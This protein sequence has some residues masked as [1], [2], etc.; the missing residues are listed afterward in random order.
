M[1]E[2]RFFVSSKLDTRHIVPK[3]TKIFFGGI[4][5]YSDHKGTCM[6]LKPSFIDRTG[7]R[8]GVVTVIGLATTKPTQATTI[9]QEVVHKPSWRLKCDCQYEWDVPIARVSYTAPQSCRNCQPKRKVYT[10]T[11]V[12]NG[13]A[14]LLYRSTHPNY[15]SWHAMILRCNDPKHIA[16]QRYGGRGIKVCTRWLN[17]DLFT[18]DMGTKPS[19]L[20][21]IDRIDNDLGYEPSNCR[22]ATSKEQKANQRPR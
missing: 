17:F 22:W 14:K 18:E 7:Q 5:T 12:A 9:G 16:F 19:Q 10:T 8:M 13:Q 15:G 21:S 6:T 20:H 2:S 3:I 11:S 4:T 1:H